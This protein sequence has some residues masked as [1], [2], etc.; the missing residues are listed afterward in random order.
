MHLLTAFQITLVAHVLFVQK[1]KTN[2]VLMLDDSTGTLQVRYWPQS[3]RLDREADPEEARYW[4]V[5]STENINTTEPQV[6][7]VI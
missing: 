3:T 6:M 1:L 2:Y 5:M 4:A 7:N